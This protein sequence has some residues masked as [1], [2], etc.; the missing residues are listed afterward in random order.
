MIKI[1]DE[2]SVDDVVKPEE[3]KLVV[4]GKWVRVDEAEVMTVQ[5]SCGCCCPGHCQFNVHTHEWLLDGVNMPSKV[6][7]DFEQFPNI[8]ERYLFDKDDCDKLI[9]CS[10]VV[11]KDELY[12]VITSLEINFNLD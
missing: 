4:S 11:E 7:I 2:K 3:V 1:L 8:F 12:D 5:M 6:A 10:H 9:K